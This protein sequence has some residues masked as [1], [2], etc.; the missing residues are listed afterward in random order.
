MKHLYFS[1]NQ[2]D[3]SSPS[4]HVE[5]RA[6]WFLLLLCIVWSKV[7]GIGLLLLL[8]AHVELLLLAHHVALHTTV[9]WH[10]CPELLLTSHLIVL[11]LLLILHLRV[12]HI[13]LLLLHLHLHHILLLCITGNTSLEHWIRLELGLLLFLLLLLLLGTDK[14]IRAGTVREWICRSIINSWWNTRRSLR[15]IIHGTTAEVEWVVVAHL[16]VL[17]GSLS[18]CAISSTLREK[19]KGILSSGLLLLLLVVGCCGTTAE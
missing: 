10:S 7:E 5:R 19:F 16:L 15:G 14:G 17:C 13:L 6:L 8:S 12:V 11:W 2:M 18:K 3:L 1:L 4:E 9:G